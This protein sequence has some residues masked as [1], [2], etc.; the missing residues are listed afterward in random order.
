MGIGKGDSLGVGTG[1]VVGVGMGA[2]VGEE[3]GGK[4]GIGMGVGAGEERGGT[5]GVGVVEGVG[6]GEERGGTVG[7]GTGIGTGLGVAVGVGAGVGVSV[8]VVKP[9]D[10][11][12]WASS[13]CS[14]SA[15]GLLGK[16]ILLPKG[17]A[18]ALESVEIVVIIGMKNNPKSVKIRLENKLNLRIES[19]AN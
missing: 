14:S 1:V 15:A 16:A 3:R 12:L 6:V 13:G 18:N 10:V 7:A 5:V 17:S 11:I 9:G 8:G 2:G 19:E 4:V